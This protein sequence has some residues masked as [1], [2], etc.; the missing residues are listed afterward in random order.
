MPWVELVIL[1]ALVQLLYFGT[2][3]GRARDKYGVKAP[4]TTGNE[5]FERYFRVQMNTVE[6]LLLFLPSIWI[7]AKY[8]S[9][10]IMAALGVIYLIG[11]F[12]YLVSYVRDP[13]KRSAGFG[14]SAL[15]TLV[16]MVCA[17]AG[18]IRALLLR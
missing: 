2:L 18:A 9:P 4:A 14:L 15:P 13:S 10:Y 12:V 5:M 17:F 3:V 11:R 6:M 7:A 16:L 1:L 8:W